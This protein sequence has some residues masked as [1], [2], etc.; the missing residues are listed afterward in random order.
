MAITYDT[1]IP[2]HRSWV[3]TAGATFT[4]TNHNG[5]TF[6]LDATA[7]FVNT[8]PSP[9]LGAWMKFVIG[10][11]PPTSG[12]GHTVVTPAGVNVIHGGAIVNSVFVPAVAEDTITF[13]QSVAVQGD[14]VLLTSDGVSWYV[15]GVGG[16]SGSIT[17]TAS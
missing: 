7:G 16:A 15:E 8:L 1:Y 5:F 14:W 2:L 13:V 6:Y 4:V 10:D 12:G 3:R 9:T 11:S 17:F